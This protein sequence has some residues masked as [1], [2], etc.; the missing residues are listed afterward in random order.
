MKK[1]ALP[2]S[3]L[4]AA[5]PLSA[6]AQST[7]LPLTPGQPQ[8]LQLPANGL[9]TS[10]VVDVPAGVRQMRV[11]LLASNT[12][13]DIDLVLRKGSPFDLRIEGTVDV[14]QLFDQ[15]HYRSVSSAGD[16]YIVVS[17]ANAIALAPGRWFIGVV[18]F[19]ASA[20]DAQL[21]ARFASEPLY[22]DVQ[23]VF[24]DPG[25]AQR[26]CDTS[27]WTD[28]TPRTP[29]RGNVGTTLGE[30]RREAAREAAR[31]L[32]EQLRPRIPVRIQACWSDLG[33]ATGTRFTLAQAGP[34]YLFVNDTGFGSH[35]PAFERDYT[36]FAAA[37]AAQQLGTSIC[38]IDGGIRC[39]SGF[40]V[41]ATFNSKLDQAGAARF[42]YGITATGSGSSFVSVAMHEILH[43]LGIFGL[44]KLQEDANGPVGAKLNLIPGGPAW[45]DVYGARTVSV[46]PDGQGFREF[47][48]ISDAERAATLSTPWRLRFAGQRAI[49]AASTL[50]FA[51]P[52]NFIR[53]HAPTTIEPGSTYSHIQSQLSYGVQLMY[54]TI[55]GA[56]PRDTGIAGGMLQDLGWRDTPGAVKT[57]GSAPSFQF[58]DPARSGHGIDFRL[59]S[60]SITGRD[61]QYFLGFYTFDGGGNPEWYISTG[62]I[63][64]GVF[65][66]ARNAFGDSLLRQNYLGPNNSVSDASAGYSGT[67]RIN[68]NNAR[69]H[70]AC[71]DGHPARR[72]D[73]PLAVMTA[74]I[75]GERIQWC[76]Q[77]V[78]VPS[79][80]RRDFSSIWYSLGDS[81]WGLAL[82]SFD[83]ANATGAPTD[84]LFSILFY[85]DAAGKPRWAIG[86]TTDF[87]PGEAQALRQVTGYCR[88]CPST[89]GIQLSDPI[90][91]M[92]LDLIQGGAGAQGNRI[93]FDLT[94][95]GTEGG[96]FQRSGVNLFPN[97]DPTLGGN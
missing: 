67:I 58:Y 32:T 66:P 96:R 83:G 80:V 73:G 14:D 90:G 39:N 24:D 33:D 63:V 82:Q 94:Y 97:S 26:P 47:L 72:L 49:A 17:D 57:F 69:L 42:D 81:G 44:I 19:E 54:P 92:T 91:S 37:A 87:R 48:R 64:D 74:R 35:F 55:G 88:T 93:S 13:R 38:R 28:P 30:Q 20:V 3:L 22:S 75:N 2:F 61:A 21:T 25:T 16:E 79:R 8:T 86:Q 29:E 31:L 50:N 60:P 78:V 9:S 15:A 41:R 40:D 1:L 5:A 53:L 12:A 10:W 4:C 84:G 85:A 65:V 11:E 36:W 89:S 27:G 18:N 76:M 7:N 46:D 51:P 77:P 68:F 52:E 70:P 56:A 34:Q 6:L 23:F 43:G 59:I 71:Q 62:P 95:P 45:D